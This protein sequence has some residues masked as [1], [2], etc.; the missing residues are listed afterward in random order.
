MFRQCQS[1]ASGSRLR[2]IDGFVYGDEG[3]RVLLQLADQVWLI[4]GVR[5]FVC[6]G[7][8]DAIS[9]EYIS[10]DGHE[11]LFRNLCFIGKE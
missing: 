10:V 7:L 9:D 3:D 8:I 6:M 4:D 2:M 1:F 11:F 5:G